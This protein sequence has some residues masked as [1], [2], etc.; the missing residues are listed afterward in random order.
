M[1]STFSTVALCMA[2]TWATAT[3]YAQV[4]APIPP[5]DVSHAQPA[6]PK[7]LEAPK[8]PHPAKAPDVELDTVTAN[9]VDSGGPSAAGVSPA[10]ATTLAPPVKITYAGS[11]S[12]ALSVTD[13]GTKRGVSSSL[14]NIANTSAAAYGQTAGTG[15]GIQGVNLGTAGSGGAFSVTVATNAD[16]AVSAVTAGTGSAIVGTVSAANSGQPAV[17]GSNIGTSYYGIGLE[18]HAN[19]IGVYGLVDA[20]NGGYGVYGYAGDGTG[21]VGLSSSGIGVVAESSSSYG[22]Y[23]ASSSSYGVY[24]SSSSS[25][26]VYGYSYQGDGVTANGNYGRAITAHSIN[27]LAIYA[28]S[29][30]GY[31]IWGQSTN[32]Y[33]V[34]GE[35]A[36]SG[37][38]VY[39]SSGTGYAGYFAGKVAATQYLT[40]SDRDAKTDFVPVDGA[41]V[42]ESIRRLPITSWAFKDTRD[43]RH[44]GPV[45]QDFHAAFGLNGEDDTHINLTDASG[46]SLA[47]IQEL[48]RQLREKD[49]RI[50]ALEGQLKS[51]KDSLSARLA[52]LEAQASESQPPTMTVFVPRNQ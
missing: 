6:H 49:A 1:K 15:P 46:V 35:D 31:G 36:G 18:G 34:I 20:G 7:A 26:G 42:L 2:C 29:D 22:V 23:A 11:G 10:V 41:A 38:G 48:D 12:N 27:A 4:P 33:G 44:V 3:V 17:I 5:R 16:P 39:G 21:A 30:N 51:L 14:T 37:I 43:V 8:I 52:K 28:S 50:A 45:A 47:A 24:G 32:Q 40:V 13:S 9:L 19:S 25:S